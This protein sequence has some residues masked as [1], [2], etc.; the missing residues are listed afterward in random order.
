M[1]SSCILDTLDRY[2]TEQQCASSKLHT[3]SIFAGVVT[4]WQA[5]PFSIAGPCKGKQ[6]IVGMPLKW[7]V[8]RLLD[9]YLLLASTPAVQTTELP[10]I[11]GI[12]TPMLRHCI[13]VIFPACTGIHLVLT[14]APF[15]TH[16][17]GPLLRTLFNPSMNKWSH[18]NNHMPSNASD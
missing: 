17:L 11:W 4:S 10:V 18:V 16:S 12:M 3:T 8:T 6:P 14:C 9:V 2:S 7:S 5:G 1:T 13:Q 15:A